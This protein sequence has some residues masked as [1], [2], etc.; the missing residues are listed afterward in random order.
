[1]A[2]L[3]KKI[4]DPTS[5]ARKTLILAHRT[6][7]LEQACNQIKRFHPDWVSSGLYIILVTGA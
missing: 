5:T 2:N 4:P 1:M 6:E 7:L 3:L